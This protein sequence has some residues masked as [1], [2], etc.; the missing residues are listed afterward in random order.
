MLSRFFSKKRLWV[1]PLYYALYMAAFW[2]LENHT[3]QRLHL[4]HTVLDDW[5]PFC[6]YFILPYLLWFP[7]IGAA[8]GYFALFHRNVRE[9]WQFCLSMAIG[10]TLFLLISWLYPNGQNLRPALAAGENIFVDLVR[11]IYQVDTST[12][13]LPSMHVFTTMA[14]ASS[15]DRCRSLK[16][17]RGFRRAVWGLSI[18]I[19]LSTLFVKQHSA[20]DMFSGILLYGGIYW[21]LYRKEIGRQPELQAENL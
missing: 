21:L 18:L 13:V 12:N 10:L 9:Y 7:F 1:I 20:I 4:L 8:V 5:I 14:V 19:I 3:P 11:M 16:K 6:E 15:L 2:A 17:Y